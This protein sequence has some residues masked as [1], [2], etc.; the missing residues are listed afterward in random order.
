MRYAKVT[1]LR[2]AQSPP[3]V[4]STT[5]SAGR[6]M[7]LAPRSSG[8]WALVTSGNGMCPTLTA[9]LAPAGPRRPELGARAE[10]PRAEG[11]R[12]GSHRCWGTQDPTRAPRARVSASETPMSSHGARYA[13]RKLAGDPG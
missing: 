11:R 6:S 7:S 8:G 3:Q 1:L 10:T 9:L 12:C 5:E 13:L 2:E 4:G